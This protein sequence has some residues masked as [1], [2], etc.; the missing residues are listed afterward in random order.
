MLVC[1]DNLVRLVVWS[2]VAPGKHTA[3]EALAGAAVGTG[4]A[5][6]FLA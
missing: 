3:P 4:F 5:L 1:V 2:R 6:L